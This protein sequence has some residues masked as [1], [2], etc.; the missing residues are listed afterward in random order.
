MYTQSWVAPR[1]ATSSMRLVEYGAHRPAFFMN[2]L[3]FLPLFCKSRNVFNFHLQ[4][5]RNFLKYR[6]FSFALIQLLQYCIF[7]L[8][9]T[10]YLCFETYSKCIFLSG[11][12]Q[13][14]CLRCMARRTHVQSQ[15][16]SNSLSIKNGN[17]IGNQGKCKNA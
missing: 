3:N 12:A 2:A 13:S 5:S 17:V 1:L 9:F 10:P 15:P 4:L 6:P 8:S 14:W 7:D 11:T 16:K